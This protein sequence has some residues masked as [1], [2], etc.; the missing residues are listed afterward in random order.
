MTTTVTALRLS[1]LIGMMIVLI[2]TAYTVDADSS[3]V[4][5]TIPEYLLAVNSSLLPT[6]E[7]APPDPLIALHSYEQG[8]KDG[9]SWHDPIGFFMFGLSGGTVFGIWGALGV[10]S[11]AHKTEAHIKTIPPDCDEQQY[12]LGYATQYRDSNETGAI[13]GGSLGTAAN[14]TLLCWFAFYLVGSISMSVPHKQLATDEKI[15]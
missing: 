2:S 5:A 15:Q 14:A 8:V 3:S 10:Y 9:G 4:Q 13:I 11:L 1:L 12:R 7:G 6:S